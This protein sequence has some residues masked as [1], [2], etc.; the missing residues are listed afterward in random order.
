MI[1]STVINAAVG[2]IHLPN[3]YKKNSQLI[4]NY[5]PIKKKPT[6]LYLNDSL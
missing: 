2:V 6:N 1:W 4:F 5:F 3:A